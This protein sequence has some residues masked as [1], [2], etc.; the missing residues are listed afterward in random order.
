M[1][2]DAIK[3]TIARGVRSGHMGCVGKAGGGACEPFIHKHELTA[4]EVEISD[5]VFIIT[6]EEAEKHIQ[7]PKLTTL[8]VSPQRVRI[9]PGKKQTF[10]A[11]GRD[12]HGHEIATPAQKWMNFYTKVLAKFAAGKGL[13]LTVKV[14]AAPDGGVSTQ[15]VE[16]TKVALRELGLSDDV[17]TS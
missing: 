11:H 6:A 16:E 15:K 2:A 12:Q 4:S 13:K 14:E 8:H 5:D 10:V 3:D 17:K 9:E 7:P 1:N